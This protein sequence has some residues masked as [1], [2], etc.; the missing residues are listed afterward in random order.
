[1]GDR[2]RLDHS[3]PG[4]GSERAVSDLRNERY[5]PSRVRLGELSAIELRE[6]AARRRKLRETRRFEIERIQIQTAAIERAE[7]GIVEDRL[8]VAAGDLEG[9]F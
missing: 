8:R 6:E 5:G 2:G 7:R 1:M 4:G 3:E 9:R